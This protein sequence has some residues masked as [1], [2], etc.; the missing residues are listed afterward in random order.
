ME[1]DENLQAVHYWTNVLKYQATN[2][3]AY[4]EIINLY[5]GMNLPYEQNRWELRKQA[6]LEKH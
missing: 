2:E 1:R 3:E 5:C 4:E 6:I